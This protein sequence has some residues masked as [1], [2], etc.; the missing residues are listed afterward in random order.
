MANPADRPEADAD[1]KPQD[2]TGEN[3]GSVKGGQLDGNNRPNKDLPRGSEGT[4]RRQSHGA[5]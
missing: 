2:Q 5:R 1:Q 4:T 3:H